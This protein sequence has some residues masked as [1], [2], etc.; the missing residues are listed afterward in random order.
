MRLYN[1]LSRSVEDFTPIAPP[2]VSLYA[3]GPTVYDYTHIG[4]L[5][6]FVMDDVLI[7]VLKHAGYQVKFVRN[8]TDVGELTSGSDTG[9][10]KLEKGAKKYNKSVW[11]IAKEF[12]NYFHKSME[13][14][15]NLEPNVS[16]RATDHIKSQLALVI[17]LEKKGHTYIIENDGVYFDTSTLSDY[18]KLNPQ[19][20]DELQEGGRIGVV[21]GKRN[22]TDFALWKFER[23]GENRA[24][25]WPSPWAERSFPGWHI[26]CSAMSMEY[27]GEQIDIHTGGID[28]I[29]VHH[30]NEIAQSEAATG[31]VPFV[32]YWVHHNFLRVEGE[33][34]SKSLENFY[35]IDDIVK[36]GFSPRALRLL[37]MG[38]QYRDELNFTW[39]SLAAVQKSYDRLGKLVANWGSKTTENLSEKAEKLHADFFNYLEDDLKTSQATAILWEM[40]KSDLSNE[41]K[42]SLFRDFDSV[43]QLGFDQES[44][45]PDKEAIP[46]EI[47]R[48]LT[49]RATAREM[50]DWQRADEL[51]NEIL[52]A[53]YKVEDVA[54]GKQTVE[55]I[56]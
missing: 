41:E 10:D 28:H 34:M 22:P 12:E 56:D 27:L 13:L 51:R 55:P 37:F 29:P 17:E 43:L 48:M 8:I 42:L 52:M 38:S 14:M 54:L 1:T 5:R 25:S 32:R 4:H 44:E 6:K 47:E 24:M 3:C 40:A 31:K 20:L 9:E 35:T 45:K 19:S 39:D 49:E 7:R 26:E 2:K 30:T 33:K 18:G 16:C 23:P 15:G 46:E 11:E 50:K 53:G 21:E 36:K